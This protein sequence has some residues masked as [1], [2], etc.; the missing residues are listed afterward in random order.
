MF[1]F[2]ISIWQ[3][4]LTDFSLWQYDTWAPPQVLGAT[5][6]ACVGKRGSVSSYRPEMPGLHLP[7]CSHTSAEMGTRF[8]RSHAP[9]CEEFLI[10]TWSPERQ[11]CMLCAGG[12]VRSIW[13]SN[14]V[15]CCHGYTTSVDLVIWAW[16]PDFRTIGEW[17]NIASVCVCSCLDEYEPDYVACDCKQRPIYMHWWD[18]LYSFILVSS[19]DFVPYCVELM[20]PCLNLPNSW[21]VLQCSAKNISVGKLPVIE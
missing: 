13:S 14:S 19:M 11:D 6:L 20:T 12:G 8:D 3:T 1:L 9:T 7:S 21:H 4:T 15:I 17:L 10:W 16:S 2:D 5:H 18:K